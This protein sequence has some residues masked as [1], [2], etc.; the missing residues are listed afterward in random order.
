MRA[1]PGPRLLTKLVL[2]LGSATSHR[3]EPMDDPE[4]PNTGA[5]FTFGK[6]KFADNAPSKFWIKNDEV[7]LISC[8]DEHTAVV[9]QSGRI[10]TFGCNEWGQLGLGHNNNVIKPSC[11]KVLKPDQ[12]VAVS[13]G[14]SHT[15]V[16]MRS[17]EVWAMGCNSEGQLGV[18]RGV[19]WVSGPR[20][21]V[22]LPHHVVQLA[23]GAGHSLALTGEGR[24]WVWGS[25]TE[26]QL[27][28]GEDSEETVF[29]PTELPLQDR[30]TQ[31][32]CGYYHSAL[33]TSQGHLLTFGEEEGG[34]LGL[35]ETEESD[36]D[37]PRLVN[38]PEPV[39]AVR[40]G[41]SHTLA[42]T[43][44]GKVY[45]FGQSS[46]GQLGLGNTVLESA[47]PRLV[48]SL[49]QLK[50]TSVS[51]GENHSLVT[52]CSGHLYTFGDGR[53]GKLCLDLE[54]LTNQFSPAHVDRFS[55]RSG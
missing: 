25:N 30:V 35:G 15:V 50:V 5:V 29:T 18:G 13:C 36:C 39:T 38:I 24:V 48:V 28:L 2:G 9:T 52:T 49:D 45:S 37:T 7:K 46:H 23:T 12:V 47:L 55:G 8:G 1:R 3:P 34:K 19:E 43:N 6:S 44:S 4:I 33:V 53:H 14:R 26:G 27:G 21:V 42:L 31:I 54:T 11:I 32:A 22:G 51:C 20:Q 41:A 16:G 17:G 10:F 40:C